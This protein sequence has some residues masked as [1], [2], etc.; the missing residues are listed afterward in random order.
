MCSS[1]RSSARRQGAHQESQPSHALSGRRGNV[2]VWLCTCWRRVAPGLGGT[3]SGRQHPRGRQQTQRDACS[4][5]MGWHASNA[6]PHRRCMQHAGHAR[7]QTQ[8]AS[9]RSV[10]HASLLGGVWR[11]SFPTQPSAHLHPSVN[12]AL[13]RICLQE[14]RRGLHFL[15]PKSLLVRTEVLFQPIQQRLA[16]GCK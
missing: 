11:S 5:S 12:V 16:T 7:Q 2:T 8:R 3:L 1:S 15:Q 6:Q 10:L 14:V 9:S 4:G 13:L